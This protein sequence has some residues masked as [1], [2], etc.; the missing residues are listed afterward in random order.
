LRKFWIKVFG[1]QMN[2]YDGDRLRTAM[3]RRGWIE[4]DEDEADVIFLVTCSIRDKAEQKVA[5]DIG[6]YDARYSESKK[7]VV[8]LTGCMAQRTGEEIAHR[9]S[10]VRL[11]SGPRHLGLVPG[12]IERALD[13]GKRVFLM[14]DDP[15]ELED[16]CVA[17]FERVNPLKAYVTISYG[18]DRFCTYC[19]VP[20][21]RGRLQSRM[22]DEILKEV[23]A[24]VK[25]GA[26]EISL[27][28]QNV[29]S[30]GKERD[31]GYSF[32]RLLSEVAKVKGVKR[33]RFATSHPRDF[34]DDI[35]EVMADNL[36]L[37]RAINLPVQS[38]SDA[39]LR[40]MNRGYTS[41]DYR[42]LV[43]RI[44]EALPDV[45]LSTD[46]I[47]GFPGETESDF[48]DSYELIQDLRFDI[49]HTA[50][51]SPR[52]GTKAAGMDSQVDRRIKAARLNEVNAMQSAMARAINEEYVGRDF[53]ILIDAPAPKG[54]GML[55]GRT[56]SDKVVIVRGGVSDIGTFAN[57]RVTGASNW[58]L[59]GEIL[60]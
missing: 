31:I 34:D 47:V 25:N 44:R 14:D 29:D 24:L 9:F 17:P 33:V 21:V 59:E 27:L 43:G 1:C 48:R 55:Q 15:R 26:V 23:E 41:D 52:P 60:R 10:C 20:Y 32:A 12:G 19:I 16:L 18:C 49:V 46:L 38:G 39:I 30:Y 6:R 22:P 8:A 28:G 56:M 7:P 58:S 4:S 40:A 36:L 3:I 2:V 54:E 11:V 42:S 50:A 57:V 37:C 53:E 13:S 45:S 35:L 5:S 51:Y